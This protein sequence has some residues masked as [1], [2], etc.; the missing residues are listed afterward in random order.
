MWQTRWFHEIAL[1]RRSSASPFVDAAAAAQNSGNG[2]NL[3]A[4]YRLRDREICVASKLIGQ[5]RDHCDNTKILISVSQNFLLPPKTAAILMRVI[6]AS[7]PKLSI[8]LC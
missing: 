3:R 7:E 2:G 5:N 6:S 4:Q 8:F 1:D